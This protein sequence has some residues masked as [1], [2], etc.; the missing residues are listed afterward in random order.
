MNVETPNPKCNRCKCYWKPTEDDIASSGLYFKTCRKCRDKQKELRENNKCEHNRDKTKCKECR[1][2]EICEHNKRKYVCKDCGGNG[3][4]IHSRDKAKC[5][6]CSGSEICVHNKRKSQCKECKGGSICIHNKFKTACKDCNLKYYLVKMQRD[7]IYRYFK[8]YSSFKK[9]K[10]SIEYLG[11]NVETL[12][13]H[14]IK[15]MEYFNTYIATDTFMDWDNI[16]IDHIKP[17]SKFNLED[18]DE[19]LNC[20]NYTNIQPLLPS[21]NRKKRNIWTEENETF[22]KVNILNNAE[23]CEIYV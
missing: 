10:N 14:F 8:L 5:K 7:T 22:W 3:I 11:C 18:E 21:N 12:I 9:T 13:K 23:Y 15:K 1:G 6:E 16:H 19:F 4:C 17:V 2:S 20:C